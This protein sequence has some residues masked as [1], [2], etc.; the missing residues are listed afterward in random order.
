MLPRKIKG[1]SV[2][3]GGRVGWKFAKTFSSVTRVVRSFMFWL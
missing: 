3:A 2:Y 1:E